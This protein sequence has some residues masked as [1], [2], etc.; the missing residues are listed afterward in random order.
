[1][2][3]N[4]LVVN[5]LIGKGYVCCFSSSECQGFFLSDFIQRGGNVFE[6]DFVFLTM[7]VKKEKFLVKELG[8]A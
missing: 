7:G 2:R 8:I 3:I 5:Q 1:M 6:K 4:E